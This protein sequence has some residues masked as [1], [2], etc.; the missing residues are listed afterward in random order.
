M[1]PYAD[2]FYGDYELFEEDPYEDI[3]EVLAPEYA[4]LHPDDLEEVLTDLLGGLSPEE[5]EDFW[6]GLKKFGKQVGRVAKKALPGVIQGA[7]T[8]FMTGGPVG[9]ILGAAGGGIASA[10]QPSLAGPAT[11]QSAGTA[12]AGRPAAVGSPATAQA[13]QM[14]MDPRVQQAL[15]SMLMGQAGRQQIPVGRTNVPVGAFP[16]MLGVLLNRAAAEY[17]ALVTPS[18]EA[19]PSYLLDATGEFIVDPAVPEERA[20]AL[21][22]L[23]EQAAWEESAYEAHEEGPIPYE[24]DGILYFEY[25]DDE[26][27]DA[28]EDPYDAMDFFASLLDDWE[29]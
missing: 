2:Y 5:L 22:G 20:A 7:A 10:L 16:N 21:L 15:M 17:N 8:G 11:P 6:S 14:L 29:D 9:G 24:E 3:R 28:D 4:S 12:L 23:L 18:G 19:I 26:L 1:I 27:D 13:L 25:L